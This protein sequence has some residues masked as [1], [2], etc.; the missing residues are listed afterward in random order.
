M[1]HS[2]SLL[3][4]IL[5]LLQT[6][7]KSVNDFRHELADVRKDVET[8]QAGFDSFLETAMPDGLVETHAAHHQSIAKRLRTWR[9]RAA[10]WL[11][12]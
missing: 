1:Q 5:L 10:D 8:L 3:N 6:L 11:K 7:N 4:E 12:G 9:Q 2:E